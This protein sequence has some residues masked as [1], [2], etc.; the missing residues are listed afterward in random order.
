MKTISKAEL[1]AKMG[2]PGTVVVNVLDSAAYDKI[3]IKGSV[4]I[5][6]SQLQA[7]KWNELD[8]NK[9]IVTHCSSYTC[10][11]SRE[12]AQFLEEQGF[13]VKAYEGGMREWAESGLPTEGRLSPEQYLAEKYGKSQPLT[14]PA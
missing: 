6:Q 9:E 14:T 13:N 4:S 3:H 12:A 8:K 1:M 2:S 10:N 11:A 5:P 7:G